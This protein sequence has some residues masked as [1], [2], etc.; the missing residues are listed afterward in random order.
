MVGV[1]LIV[2]ESKELVNYSLA[3]VINS[4]FKMKYVDAKSTVSFDK[5]KY[6]F[7]VHTLILTGK[8]IQCRSY[9]VNAHKM[10]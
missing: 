5:T 10:R 4:E 8:S 2:L 9:W 6:I 3:L 7:D 1:S